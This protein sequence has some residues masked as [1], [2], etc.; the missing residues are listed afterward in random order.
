MLSLLVALPL[1]AQEKESEAMKDKMSSLI[2]ED[3]KEAA[4]KTAAAKQAGKAPLA[5]KAEAPAAKPVA[6]DKDKPV[7]LPELKVEASKLPAAT[8]SIVE[9]HAKMR[10]TQD[11]IDREKEHTIQ[12]DTDKALNGDK[13]SVMGP[14][15]SKARA[16]DAKRRIEEN[17][18]KQSVAACVA[19]PD[20]EEENKKLL[21]ML[22]DLEYQKKHRQ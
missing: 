1:Y 13:I 18:V 6:A 4:S 9:A 22:E 12:T 10:E 16:D 7:D 11:T 15:S 19:D 20:S 21:K 17:E 14:L 8:P 3:S 2:K 5:A